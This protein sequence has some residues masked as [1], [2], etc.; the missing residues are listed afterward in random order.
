MLNMDNQNSA[1][2]SE[3]RLSTERG[4]EKPIVCKSSHSCPHWFA[5][6]ELLRPLSIGRHYSQIDINHRS[7]VD[8]IDQQVRPKQTNLIVVVEF[9]I[10]SNQKI[11]LDQISS[12]IVQ[13]VES[14]K[15]LVNEAFRME[16]GPQ[17]GSA[18]FHE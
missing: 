5:H 17:T 13:R 7:I 9:G 11:K 8:F 1:T 3:S 18:S 12:N 15:I 10:T 16:T 2:K 14:T 6:T 4:R